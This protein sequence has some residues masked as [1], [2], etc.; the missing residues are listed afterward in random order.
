MA[1]SAAVTPKPNLNYYYIKPT[2]NIPS[3]TLIL[4][5]IAIFLYLIIQKNYISIN[6]ENEKCNG[7]N[8][9]FAPLYGQDSATTIQQC[10]TDIINKKVDDSINKL[11][12]KDK[13]SELNTNVK[14]F[15]TDLNTKREQ[16][17]G[18]TYST[19][20]TTLTAV[21]NTVDT[22]KK[23]LSNVLGS[24]ILNSYMA[25]GVIQS[26]QSLQNTDLANIKTQY[27]NV[28]QKYNANAADPSSQVSNAVKNI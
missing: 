22:I 10:T 12:L 26:T 11:N 1:D 23:T 16:N 7:V 21:S 20:A 19:A 15:V 24:V 27:T 6:W 28:Q 14:D 25:D 9:F 8:F 5:I 18:D 13:L 3:V 17:I 4:I 2:L